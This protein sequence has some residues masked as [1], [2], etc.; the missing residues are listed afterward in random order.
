MGAAVL[1]AVRLSRCAAG[2][3]PWPALPYGTRHMVAK[4][5]STRNA[6]APR[7]LPASVLGASGRVPGGYAI[8]HDG[9]LKEQANLQAP[10]PGPDDLVCTRANTRDLEY[11]LAPMPPPKLGWHPAAV[12]A[13]AVGGWA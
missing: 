3:P 1:E 5:P 8:L 2:L 4:D 9:V 6:F 13:D 12:G 11:P 7:S 10:N